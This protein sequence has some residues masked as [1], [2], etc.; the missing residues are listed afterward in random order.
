M[1]PSLPHLPQ[2]S[3]LKTAWTTV[4]K[5]TSKE[6]TIANTITTANAIAC[7]LFLSLL[8]VAGAVGCLLAW[9]S[10]RT[11][12]PIEAIVWLVCQGVFVFLVFLRF[13]CLEEPPS[14]TLFCLRQF[15]K[16]V[17]VAACQWALGIVRARVK[18]EVWSAFQ[19]LFRGWLF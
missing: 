7:L 10:P 12:S 18:A 8:A 6:T 1:P 15:F 9:D 4:K 2:K 3:Q 19:G 11:D 16:R 5:H 17:E 14:A 13:F